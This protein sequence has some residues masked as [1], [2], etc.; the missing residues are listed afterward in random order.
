M[1]HKEVASGSTGHPPLQA[2]RPGVRVDQAAARLARAQK[3]KAELEEKR[4]GCKRQSHGDCRCHGRA[5]KRKAR[6]HPKR[7]NHRPWLSLYHFQ[8]GAVSC[9]KSLATDPKEKERAKRRCNE[10][11]EAAGITQ[12]AAQEEVDTAHKL[13]L[14]EYALLRILRLH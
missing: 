4:A 2:T 14:G 6:S 11:H 9:Q 1:P 8:Q 3:L 12:E 7:P 5:R 13:T 10:S